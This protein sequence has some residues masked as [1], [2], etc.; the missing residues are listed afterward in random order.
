[1]ATGPNKE[2]NSL[3]KL[4]KKTAR[5]SED[6]RF[7]NLCLKHNVTPKSHRITLN[8]TLQDATRNKHR[9]EKELIR[10]SICEL[11]KKLNDVTLRTYS[12]HLRFAKFEGH[13]VDLYESI[14]K[15]HTAFLCE[16]LSKR[17]GMMKKLNRM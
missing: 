14:S 5:I 16:K 15:L 11:Y 10:R 2:F 1:M 13:K 9:M 12:T 17:E 6:I 7:L 8:P 3:L 4:K